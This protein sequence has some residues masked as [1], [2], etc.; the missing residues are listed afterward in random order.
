MTRLGEGGWVRLE[1]DEVMM[2]MMKGML[3]RR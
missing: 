2:I 1:A 3:T